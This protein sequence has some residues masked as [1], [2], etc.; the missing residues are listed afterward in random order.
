MNLQQIAKELDKVAASNGGTLLPMAVVNA[1]RPVTAPLHSQFEWNEHKNSEAH[2]L[3][4][5]RQLITRVVVRIEPTDP[6][7]ETQH[8]VSIKSDRQA[9]NGYRAMVA[10]MSDDALRAE[11]L[12]DAREDMR[13]FQRKYKHL[14]ELAAVFEAMNAV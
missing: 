2:L 6:K 4:Q 3:W 13:T 1:A 14:R 8:Y 10:V 7:S 5:A 11:L 12:N 9:G